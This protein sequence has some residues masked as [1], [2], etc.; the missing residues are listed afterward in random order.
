MIASRIKVFLPML[1]PY[2]RRLWVL[3][4]LTALLSV[5]AMIPPLIM[6]AIV[7]RVI[8]PG[9][10]N[11]FFMLGLAMLLLP[12]M[13]AACSYIQTIGI[14]YV[15]Q[16]FVFDMRQALYRHL[17]RLSMRF[18]GKTGVGMLVNRLMGDTG[19]VQNLLTAQTISIV[20][21]L[22][23]SAFAITATFLINWRL[24]IVIV[25]LMF[26]FVINARI[27][28]GFLRQTNRNYQ[29]SMDRLSAGLQDRLITS[30]VVKSYGAEAR[31]Q[32]VFRDQSDASLKQ[33]ST[34]QIANT[35]FSYNT[36]LLA[37]AGRATIYFAG[38]AMVLMELMTYGDV[39]AFTTYALQLLW[40]AVRFSLLAKQ[41]QDVGVAADRLTE[42]FSEKPEI[43]D[44]P[45]AQVIPRLTG[46]VDFDHVDF[47]YTE[48]KPIIRDFSLH[49]E[50]GQTVALIGPTGCGKSTLL[51]LLLRFFDVTGGAL[52]LDDQD[53]RT[54]QLT[55]LRRQFGIVLQEPQLFTASI[56]DNIR[57]ARPGATQAEVEA[58]ARVAEIHDFIMSLPAGYNTLIGVEGTQLSTGQ[59]QR[60]TIARAVAANPAI[61][62]MDEATSAL[63]SESEEA[64]QLAMERLLKNRTAFIVAHRLSTI[65][66][67]NLIVLM[68]QGQILEQG[69]HKDLMKIPGGHYAAIYA[70]FMGRGTLEETPA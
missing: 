32:R 61:L 22:I 58:A 55:K 27:N 53:V 44:A 13:N 21:D 42:L 5:L 49:V 36:Q 4:G 26:I 7:D 47:H 64:I 38:C 66:T 52:R 29:R 57:Y 11:P 33:V 41:I 28:I 68:N 25:I 20:S 34:M 40:P 59:K 39:L 46:R 67:A 3:L 18:F 69:N 48:G 8:T 37:D 17:L 6:R 16:K 1:S 50:P 56:A 15:G 63:D 24:A 51:S 12:M 62:I 60:I 14:T 70:K 54:V 9:D 2:K 43:H 35:T 23:C 31:E 65:R 10:R 45:D 30:L 19:A